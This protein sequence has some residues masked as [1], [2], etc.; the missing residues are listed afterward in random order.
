M[1]KDKILLNISNLE[2]LKDYEKLGITN[3]LFPL[4][5]FSVGYDSFTY[6]EIAKI[7]VDAYILI[8]RLLTDDDIDEFIKLAIPSNVKGFVIEDT[9]LYEVL[10]DKGYTL[11]NFQNHLNANTQTC[12]YWLDY[13]DSLVISTDITKEEIAEILN[14][15]KQPL[16]LYTF[17]YTQ[18]MYS[19][20][21]LVSNYY[22]N[23][24][25][26]EKKTITISDAKG[27]FAF[28]LKEGDYGT[29]CLDTHI[30][31]TRSELDNF[32]DEKILFYLVNTEGITKD[33]I[34]KAIENE[35]VQG[36]TDG[37][38]NKKTVYRVGD[39]K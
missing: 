21:S 17:G 39:L 12:N 2:D 15:T 22:K 13:F 31:D 7:N 37:F 30:L 8:N 23:F 24:A 3:F 20:R 19:R 38:L 18:I 25:L 35:E 16:V 28:R 32:N 29:V 33:D 1:K 4:D 9:G 14:N 10:K 5:C 34:M 26:K 36:T 11:I 27:E 6:E